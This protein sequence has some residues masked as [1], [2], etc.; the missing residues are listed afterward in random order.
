MRKANVAFAV[1]E[2][3]FDY[4]ISRAL[5]AEKLLSCIFRSLANRNH[6]RTCVIP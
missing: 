6:D 3:L 1:E 4:P 2:S 5:S